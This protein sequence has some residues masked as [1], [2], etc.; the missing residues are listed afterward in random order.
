MIRK[1]GRV[2]KRL[3]VTVRP[4]IASLD[5]PWLVEVGTT[6]N[7][8]TRGARILLKD[9]WRPGERV[10]LELPGELDSCEAHVVYYELLRTGTTAVGLEL[11]GPCP[12]WMRPK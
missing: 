3:A 1:A 9:A 10:A 8:S 12:S 4:R 5:R 11:A 7:V 2:E 6:E